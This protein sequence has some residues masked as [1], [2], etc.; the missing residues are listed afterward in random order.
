MGIVSL[1]QNYA[2][3]KPSSRAV[4]QALC[5]VLRDL[6]VPLPG[7]DLLRE[8]ECPDP[9]ARREFTPNSRTIY[10]T[11]AIIPQLLRETRR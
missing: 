1:N 2:P 6:P 7:A 8:P 4:G 3:Q 10:T 5:A 9:F 11:P